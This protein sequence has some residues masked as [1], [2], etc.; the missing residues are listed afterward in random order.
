MEYFNEEQ[1]R[2]GKDCAWNI[3]DKLHAIMSELG[4]PRPYKGYMKEKL[5]SILWDAKCLM[6]MCEEDQDEQ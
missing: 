2:R 6:S 3:Q 5:E 4:G 1:I